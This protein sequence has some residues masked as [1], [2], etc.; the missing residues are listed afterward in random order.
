VE[1]RDVGWPTETNG[2]IS[3]D[4]RIY[5]EGAVAVAFKDGHLVLLLGNTSEQTVCAP[6][7]FADE[8]L[9]LVARAYASTMA[10]ADL[11][12]L[13]LDSAG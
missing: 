4:V 1:R 13:A 9:L 2:N 5:K 8:R 11:P 10:S 7:Y 3:D 6:V 12:V